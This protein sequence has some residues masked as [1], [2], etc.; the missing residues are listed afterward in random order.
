MDTKKLNEELMAMKQQRDNTENVESITIKELIN[1]IITTAFNELIT[2]DVLYEIIKD[3]YR[4]ALKNH[5]ED[6]P[7]YIT[8]SMSFEI[9]PLYRNTDYYIGNIENL[10]AYTDDGG[11]SKYLNSDSLPSIQF[12]NSKELI[13]EKLTTFGKECLENIIYSNKLPLH[14]ATV[15]A[16]P[17]EGAMINPNASN[18]R[19]KFQTY[20]DPHQGD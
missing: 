20:Y 2:D 18:F 12:D 5:T 13:V 15:E 14:I 3:K 19:I 1:F 4:D 6:N 8:P 11:R 9:T 10:W 7:I 17:Y 16:E